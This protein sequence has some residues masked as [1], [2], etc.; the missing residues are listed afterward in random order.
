M[1][2][3]MA[4]P[5]WIPVLAMALSLVACGHTPGRVQGQQ[6]GGKAVVATL[7][8]VYGGQARA[9]ASLPGTVVASEQVQMGSR[10]SGYLRKLG[11]RA[12]QPV[13]AGQI[14]FE[15]DPAGVDSQVRQAQADLAQA[16]AAFSEAQS[17][18]R[19]FGKLYAAQAVPRQQWDQLRSRYAMA[20]AR[21]AAARAGAARARS[22]QRYARVVAPFSGIV[23]GK[24]MQDGD[25]AVPGHPILALANPRHL[26]VECSVSTPLF[27][28]LHPREPVMVEGD[29][30]S[31][32]A[33]VLDLVPVADPVTHT[34]LVKLAL[35]AGGGGLQA[36]SFVRVRIPSGEQAAVTV[37][38]SALLDRA[39]IPGVFVVDGQGVAHYRMVRPGARSGDRV[40][41]LAGL[42][43]GER[44]VAGSEPGIGNGVRVVAARASHG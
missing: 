22:L 8:T 4:N 25:L 43:P 23:T 3:R 41:I 9:Y 17:D 19:R 27:D 16:K 28:R 12:G 30:K 29:G 44:I 15:V 39:G 10:L 26:E 35:P 11:V 18:Y 36:G 34:H 6:Q 1:K 13:K 20:R 14:L 2:V 24:F 7:V 42:N 32:A 37:P 5:R 33:T 40:E 31:V 38:A 21:M